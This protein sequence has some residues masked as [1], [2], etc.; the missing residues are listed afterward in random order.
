MTEEDKPTDSIVGHQH[1]HP[2]PQPLPDPPP[3]YCTFQGVTNYPPLPD[4]HPAIGFSQPFPP[5][6]A[7]NAGPLPTYYPGYQVVP[8]IAFDSY[9]LFSLLV[10]IWAWNRNGPNLVSEMVIHVMVWIK[11]QN[12]RDRFS[13]VLFCFICT[14]RE[15]ERER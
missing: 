15:R 3:Q 1:H 2:L 10:L 7:V 8:G 9:F 12:F 14:K 11:D 4:P 5:V 6:S 13:F